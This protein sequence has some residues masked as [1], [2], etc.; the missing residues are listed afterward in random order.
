MGQ[1]W[2]RHSDRHSGRDLVLNLETHSDR[3]WVHHL[4]KR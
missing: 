4:E 2:A 3:H 1:H